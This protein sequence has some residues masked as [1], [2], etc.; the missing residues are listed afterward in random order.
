MYLELLPFAKECGVKIVNIPS[1]LN[2][3]GQG[4]QNFAEYSVIFLLISKR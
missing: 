3:G 4:V 2:L 1:R